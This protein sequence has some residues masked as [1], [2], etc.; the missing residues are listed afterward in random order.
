MKRGILLAGGLA[1]LCFA[2][3]AAGVFTAADIVAG[4]RTPP[5]LRLWGFEDLSGEAP[6][7]ASKTVVG[8]DKSGSLFYSLIP[9]GERGPAAPLGVA[10]RQEGSGG[11]IGAYLYA[12]N[13]GEGDPVWGANAI[14]RT[15]SGHPA[16]GM[17]VNGVNES[18]RYGLVRGIDIVNSGNAQTQW[19]LG[20]LTAQNGA[21]GQPRYGIVLGGPAHGA[22][23][24]PASRTGLLIDHIDSGEAIQIAAGDFITLDGEGGR[25]RMRYNPQVERIEFYNG[26][27]LAHTIPM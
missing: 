16:V 10:L 19:A 1:V 27:R 15:Y 21:A 23:A 6:I 14:A 8:D 13:E 5:K 9:R 24:A 18:G 26:D 3:G 12:E 7:Y 22:G 25:I 11:G 4:D 2:S 17:E 20:I